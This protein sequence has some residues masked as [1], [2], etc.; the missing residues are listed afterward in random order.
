M[1]ELDGW[2]GLAANFEVETRAAAATRTRRWPSGGRSPRRCAA[3]ASTASS[4]PTPWTRAVDAARRRR[5]AGRG[6]RPR[7]RSR[8]RPARAGDLLDAVPATAVGPRSRPLGLELV[9]ACEVAMADA[10]AHR[11]LGHADWA[12]WVAYEQAWRPAAR[13]AAGARRSTRTSAPLDSARCS[14]TRPLAPLRTGR[15]PA[16]VRPPARWRR[17]DGLR[18]RPPAGPSPT[19]ASPGCGPASAS[20]SRSPLPPHYRGR[21]HRHLPARGRGLRRR[22]PAVVRPG[23]RGQRPAGSG[24][25]APPPLV[26]GDTLIGEDEVTAVPADDTRR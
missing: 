15:Q 20:P 1:W 3:A 2:D 6:L 19:R 11:P 26:G 23:L 24:P 16:G 12:T 4:C 8:S 25:I 5:R 21:S 10:E 17:S 14:S 22:Q 9:G 7:A 13:C 18:S